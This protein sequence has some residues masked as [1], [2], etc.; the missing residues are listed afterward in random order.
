MADYSVHKAKH[1]T[2][3]ASTVDVVTLGKNW[4]RVEVVNRDG[5]A[6]IFVRLG[7]TSPGI[8]GDDSDVLPAAIGSVVMRSEEAGNT[9]VR[10]ISA[11]TPAY[12][13][14]GVEDEPEG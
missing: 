13:V 9:V 7:S 11:G 14:I 8:N 3:G 4:R 1:A 5:A 2:L 12:S 10:L 6:A